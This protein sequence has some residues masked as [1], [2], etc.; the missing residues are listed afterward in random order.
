M[1]KTLFENGVIYSMED[2][3]TPKAYD[4]MIIKGKKILALG[5]KDT[6]VKNHKPKKRVDLKGQTVLPGLFDA[7]GHFFI[8]AV[9][10]RLLTPL[11]TKP[12]GN[13]TSIQDV[14]MKLKKHDEQNRPTVIGGFGLDDTKLNEYKLPDRHDLDRVSKEKP[15]VV[16]HIS[17]HLMSLNTKALEMA[18]I[19]GDYEAPKGSKAY[20]EEDGHFSG[21]LEEMGV[22]FR[23]FE[24]VLMPFIKKNKAFNLVEGA[25][26]D[27]LAKGITTVNE[28]A[29][30][31]NQLRMYKIAA[32]LGKLKT[33]IIFNKTVGDD[34][35][36]DKAV[37]IKQGTYLGL[38]KKITMGPMKMFIDGSIQGYTAHLKKP[39]FKPHKTRTQD[40]DYRGYAA[41]D[42]EDYEEK[43]AYLNARDR[44]Y[45]THGNGDQGIENII[46]TEELH[47]SDARNIVIHSQM[48]SEDHLKR[49][50]KLDMEASFFPMHMYVWGKPHREQ[51]LGE[52][53]AKRLDPLKSAE[54]HGVNYTSHNDAPVTPPDPFLLAW[55]A[56]A[57]KDEDGN[58]LGPGQK[59]SAYHAIRSITA[60]AASQYYIE[61]RGILKEGNLADF[62]IIDKDPFNVPKD[63]IKD[64]KV[65][66]TY[67]GG[68][69]VF[70]RENV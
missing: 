16:V 1:A 32:L 63:A 33:R 55:S 69:G 14:I 18:G 39:Y 57:R 68:T 27:Y 52:E 3:D 60:N 51:Y 7:H 13:V 50:A 36:K 37:A 67:F 30:A 48:A 28:G 70:E 23:V 6:L 25:S 58:V 66:K 38:F 31:F 12:L 15:V 46:T 26:E 24:K 8:Q 9:Y 43:V 41:W 21:V 5:D 11:F 56:V 35:R 40:E 54:K 59:V 47:P 20:K 22:I 45:A 44:Q 49:M 2:K 53:R 4:A 65:L 29:G 17:N 62:I 19:T 64:I 34:L 42:M 61:D 10:S